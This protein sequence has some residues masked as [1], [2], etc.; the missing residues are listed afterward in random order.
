MVSDLG[1][2]EHE[3]KYFEELK[4]RQEDRKRE[5]EELFQKMQESNPKIDF[6]TN[7]WKEADR[8]LIQSSQMQK[9]LR[10]KTIMEQRKMFGQ[11]LKQNLKLNKDEEKELFLQ[12]QIDK[13]HN[14]SRYVRPVKKKTEKEKE[15]DMLK[16]PE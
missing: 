6:Q 8:E 15:Q 14:P 5:W 1:I 4:K 2:L 7:L 13:I 16:S 3:E 12:I 10:S 11:K 9:H